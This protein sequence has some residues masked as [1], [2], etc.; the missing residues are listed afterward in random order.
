MPAP[1][2]L[3]RLKQLSVADLILGALCISFFGMA[4]GT[5]PPIIGG[6]LA[7]AVWVFS[8]RVFT[9][10]PR[11]L[12]QRWFWPVLAF[13]LVPWIGLLYSPGAG[14]L[15]WD[16]ATKTHYW[17]YGLALAAL[18]LLQKTAPGSSLEPTSSPVEILL[19]AFL[20]GLAI[21]ALVG[22]L[23]FGGWLTTQHGW[24][25]GLGRGYSTLSA[26]LI[27]GILLVSFYYR[28][29]TPKLKLGCILLMAVYFLHLIILEGRTGYVTFAAVSPLIAWNLLPRK[30]W[31][32]LALV[33]CVLLGG[34]LFSPVVQQRLVLTWEQLM[35]HHRENP[36]VAWGKG[37]TVHQDRFY[38]WMGA[39]RVFRTSPLIGVGTG[40]YGPTLYAMDDGTA[41]L[42]SH[43]H[44]DLLYMTANF[45]LVGI[46][47]FLWFFA[48]L[49]RCAWSVRHVPPGYFSLASTLVILISGLFNAQILD[50][51]MAFLLAVTV[52]LSRNVV[53]KREN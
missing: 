40:G 28:R 1:T 17:L 3:T 45:G 31:L 33:C 35:Y 44:N 19:K 12:R 48:E 30:S 18:P 5:T 43:P 51:G 36:E 29:V 16:Y 53:Q 22:F 6:A 50:A 42:I 38:M 46:A 25:S 14:G 2:V 7:A 4:M 37:Y 21:N 32:G 23:Q 34:M 13:I 47:V 49:L 9:T 20:L 15:G 52:G 26:Y 27:I 11:F 10:L 24:Y 41:P 39:L 8:G